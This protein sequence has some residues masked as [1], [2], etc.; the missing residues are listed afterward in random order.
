MKASRLSWGG[1]WHGE[2]A[3][4]EATQ[5]GKGLRVLGG[6]CQERLNSCS[7]LPLR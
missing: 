5:E 3:L 6:G 4:R 1:L 2:A 7:R